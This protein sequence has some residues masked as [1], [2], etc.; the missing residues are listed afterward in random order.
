MLDI[1]KLVPLAFLVAGCILV[2]IV[3]EKNAQVRTYQSKQ[4]VCLTN[5]RSVRTGLIRYGEN[6]SGQWPTKENWCD[7]LLEEG[8][9]FRPALICP[10]QIDGPSTFAINKNAHG[11]EWGEDMSDM[12]FAFESKPGW[13]QVGGSELVEIRNHSK[14]GLGCHVLFGDGEV[15]WIPAE[16]VPK[17]RW[18]SVENKEAK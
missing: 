2:L 12:V 1:K 15:R 6:N 14:L 5:L 7:L 18:G 13:N 9:V 17:L 8:Y 11:L 10:M 4:I 16:D 3:V